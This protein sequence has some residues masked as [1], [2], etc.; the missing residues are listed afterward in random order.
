MLCVV[1][2][3]WWSPAFSEGAPLPW[4]VVDEAQIA[5]AEGG[6][7]AAGVAVAAG[8]AGVG[9]VAQGLVAPLADGHR[10]AFLFRYRFQ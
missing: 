7:S 6:D 1:L 2:G 8:A 3:V 4:L 5:V 9:Q 10:G